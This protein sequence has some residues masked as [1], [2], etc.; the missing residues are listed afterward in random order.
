M[1]MQHSMNFPTTL[2]YLFPLL[3]ILTACTST[4][5]AEEPPAPV[6]AAEGLFDQSQSQTLGLK[7]IKGEH[8][9]LYRATQGDFQFCHHANLVAFKGRLYAMWSNGRVHEDSNGQRVLICHSEDGLHWTKPEILVDDPDGK[10]GPMA[11]VAAGFL[12]AGDKLIAYYTSIVHQKPI[13]PKNTLYAVESI[14]AKTWGKPVRIAEGFF[15]DGPRRLKSGRLLL[16]GQFANKQPHLMFSDA[17]DGLTGWTD[18]KIPASDIFSFPEPTWFTRRDGRVVILFRTRSG[19]FQLYAS[20]SRDDGKTWSKPTETNFPDATA[21]SFAGN[22]PDGTAFL[23]NNPS[24]TPSSYPTVGRRIPLTISLSNDGVTFNRA[25]V[26]RG[27]TTDMRYKGKSKLAGWQYPAA[28]AWKGV[29]YVIYSINKED[30]G[31]TR[32]PLDALGRKP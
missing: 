22:L 19:N 13:H 6:R 4:I 9:P 2:R 17:S 23:I 11:C 1:S 12:V 7:T 26:I 14:D 3:V 31:L 15:I 28:L 30:V 21:R 25:F 10:D 5:H 16:V 27:E 8:V 32:I 20:V 18:G 29:L 24:Q